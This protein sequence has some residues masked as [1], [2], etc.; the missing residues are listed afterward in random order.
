VNTPA[1]YY[2]P[3]EKTPHPNAAK[4]FIGW[5]HTKAA[6]V[7]FRENGRG[8]ASPCSASPVAQAL[9]DN[10]I[11]HVRI[12]RTLEEIKQFRQFVKEATEIMGWATKRKTK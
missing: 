11:E 4:L 12:G 3:K 8:L 2:T 9:C 6:K 10:G 5:A 7:V 1:G